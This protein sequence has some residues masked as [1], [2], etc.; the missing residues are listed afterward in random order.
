MKKGAWTPGCLVSKGQEAAS[1]KPWENENSSLLIQYKGIKQQWE[2]FKDEIRSAKMKR[3]NS[4]DIW[5]VEGKKHK[6]EKQ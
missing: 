2:M 1:T 5:G 6:T 3:A 4:T